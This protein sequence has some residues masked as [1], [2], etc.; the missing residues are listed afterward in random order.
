MRSVAL[1][2]TAL[3]SILRT[4]ECTQASAPLTPGARIRFDAPSLGGRQTGTLV[5]W[6]A[7]TLSVSV[8]GYAAGLV[9]IVP[10][11]SVTDLAVGSERR[12]T[13]EG[14]GLGVVAGTVLALIASPDVLD[15]NGDCTTL[16][17]IAY[18]VSPHVDTRIAVLSGI[19]ALLG[20]IA[21]SLT[22]TATWTTVPLQRLKVGPLPDGGVALGVRLSF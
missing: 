18:Q 4:A 20:A 13:L 12:M 9:L 17:C 19:G 16:E 11:D 7:D 1:I 10:T 6:Q 2:S 3:L 5:E 21:G 15:E 22:K 14:L 8:D